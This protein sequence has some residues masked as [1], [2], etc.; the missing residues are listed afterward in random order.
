MDWRGDP[1]GKLPPPA[2]PEGRRSFGCPAMPD[3]GEL[4]GCAARMQA[5]RDLLPL[6]AGIAKG[7][8]REGSIPAGYTYLGQFLA[9]DLC[10]PSEGVF[11]YALNGAPDGVVVSVQQPKPQARGVPLH[12]ETLFGP[13]D[14]GRPLP[15][16][17]VFAARRGWPMVAADL[18]RKPG[19]K[20]MQSRAAVHDPRNDDTPMV[21]QLA[22]L[23]LLL[24]CRA[25]VAFLA[26]G[27]GA[28]AAR[29]AA[30]ASAARV[31]HRILR[32]DY[33]PRLCLPGF[34]PGRLASIEADITAA[35]P[36]ELSHAVLRMGHW[37][38]RS[39]YRLNDLTV[40][41]SKLLAGQSGIEQRRAKAGAED[42]WRIDWRHFFPLDPAHPPQPSLA[43]ADGVAAMFGSDFALPEAMEIHSALVRS[44]ND[45]AL[46]DLARS[47]DGGLQR[48]SALATRLAPLKPHWPDWC[49]WSDT[50]RRDVLRDWCT[51]RDLTPP[52][53]L[54]DDPPLYLYVLAEAGEGPAREGFGGG[55]TLGALG[56]ALLAGSVLTAIAA[57][58]RAMPPGLP[59]A[60]DGFDA[61][62]D[63]PSLIRFLST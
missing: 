53:G 43:L 42:L 60:P 45:L 33:L 23:F 22:A 51:A 3:P 17:H 21:S 6:A 47:L 30:Q 54:P 35:I 49:L 24:A 15:A 11:D 44:D 38:V 41:T 46:R 26:D 34:D 18:P 37:M 9:H 16:P 10:A 55:R 25:E 31:W 12:L 59:A 28:P 40:P 13:L 19:D 56:S 5:L 2:L 4:H 20:P 8:T 7:S 36:V 1:L 14:A 57:A 39:A 61:V 48:V 29:I 52:P 58:E 63:M 50:A 62:A 27:R 32:Q